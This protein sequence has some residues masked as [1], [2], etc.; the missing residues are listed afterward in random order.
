MSDKKRVVKGGYRATL[1]LIISVIAL[2]LAIAAYKRTGSQTELNA[3]I[4]DLRTKM[5]K[6]KQE[7]TE[8]VNN[9]RQETKKA[10]EKVGIT[11]G[12][13]ESKP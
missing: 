11:I 2:I 9:V 4:R 13:K 7:T 8:R 1:A 10:L 5:E 12:R 6:M 3:E